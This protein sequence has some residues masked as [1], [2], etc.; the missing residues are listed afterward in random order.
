MA[1]K[2][3][4]ISRHH[5]YGELSRAKQLVSASD[6]RGWRKE[7]TTSYRKEK[8]KATEQ[9]GTRVCPHVENV[10]DYASYVPEWDLHIG[11]T[12]S[13][14]MVSESFTSSDEP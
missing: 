9:K 3:T 14:D 13:E 6:T 4:P 2:K 7:Q 11:H 12:E 10:L 1:R 5:V 8:R